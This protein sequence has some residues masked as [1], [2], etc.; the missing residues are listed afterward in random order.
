METLAEIYESGAS[1]IHDLQ[2]Q[3]KRLEKEVKRLRGA[4]TAWHKRVNELKRDNEGWEV[5]MGIVEEE[6]RE[7]REI[8][9]VFGP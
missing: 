6:L 7:E 9:G 8:N 5:Q 4:N 3:V 2:E 1:C